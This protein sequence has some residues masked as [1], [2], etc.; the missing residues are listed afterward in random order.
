[1][2]AFTMT[3]DDGNPRRLHLQGDAIGPNLQAV[4]DAA[5]DLLATSPS[6]LIV[7]VAGVTA[8]GSRLAVLLNDLARHAALHQSSVVLELPDDAADWLVDASLNSAIHVER[9]RVID[10]GAEGHRAVPSAVDGEA[11]G[12]ARRE[13][14]GFVSSYGQGRRCAVTGCSTTLS[15]YNRDVL[16]W[17]HTPTSVGSQRP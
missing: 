7:N 14:R 8:G 2:S 12:V 11:D 13:G 17:L 3:I 10:D 9:T 15:R 16:C 1:M 5:V 6:Q 4:M